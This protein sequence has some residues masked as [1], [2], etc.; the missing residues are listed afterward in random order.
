[1]ILRSMTELLE[2]HGIR[3]ALDEHGE[4]VAKTIVLKVDGGLAMAVIPVDHQPR[5]DMLQEIVNA[6][7]VHEA[8]EGE[9]QDVFRGCEAQAVP[10][11]GT[12]QSMRV[13]VSDEL[14]DCNTLALAAGSR[15][16]VL[17]IAYSDYTRL[18]RPLVLPLS[19]PEQ[20]Q[21]SGAQRRYAE[22][23]V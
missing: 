21:T 16:Q 17:R 7:S 15:K 3:Y 9:V 14:T 19:A 1:M 23:G 13:F 20:E 12:L 5:L 4:P 10:P 2:S 18:V 6:E 8:D 22:V 11:F